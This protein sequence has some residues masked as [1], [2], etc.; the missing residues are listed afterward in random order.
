MAEDGPKEVKVVTAEPAAFGLL[1]LAIVTLVACAIKMGWIADNTTY[2]GNDAALFLVPWAFFFGATAQFVT[3]LMEFRRNNSFGATAFGAYGMFWFALGLTYL[4]SYQYGLPLATYEK[5]FMFAFIGMLI[6]NTYMMYGSMS[7]NK[8]LFFVFFF[9]ELFF[10]GLIAATY[11][12]IP[13]YFAGLAE[14]GVSIA[15]F[16]ASAAIILNNMAGCQVL[17]VGKPLIKLAKEK[18]CVAPKDVI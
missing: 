2:A 17:P 13:G 14:L 18:E 10:I 4:W 6:F 16:Y 11:F 9:I 12:G 1:G 15:S 5:Q 3:A 7:L 8:A